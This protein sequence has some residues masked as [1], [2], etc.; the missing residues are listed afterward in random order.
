MDVRPAA[1]RRR[2]RHN[3][4]RLRA[5]GGLVAMFVAGGLLGALGFNY[6]GYVCVVP[7]AA[8]LLALSV[9]PLRRDLPRSKVLLLR[10][11][12]SATAAQRSR[13]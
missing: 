11:R 5:A 10:W 13:P 4:A 7:L 1:R 9:P 2:V 3:R 6:V 12:S 8:L